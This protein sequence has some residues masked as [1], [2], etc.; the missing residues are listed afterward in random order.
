MHRLFWVFCSFLIVLTLISAIGGGIRYRENFMDEVLDNMYDDVNQI[1]SSIMRTLT[2]TSVVEEEA[3]MNS[4][5]APVPTPMPKPAPKPVPVPVPVPKPPVVNGVP[6][7]L[8]KNYK[9]S[10]PCN[11]NVYGTW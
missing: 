6:S 2:S 5:P 4:T 1:D 10:E 3:I 7:E 8:S 11:G 9:V